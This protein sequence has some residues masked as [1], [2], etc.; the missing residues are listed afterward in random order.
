[1]TAYPFDTPPPGI[2]GELADFLYRAAN[3]PVPEIA[4]A[5]SIAYLAGV[6]GRA[7]NVS[8][9]GLNQYVLLVAGTGRGKEGARSG[10]QKFIAHATGNSW[11]DFDIP[12]QLPILAEYMGPADIASGQALIRN[13]GKQRS[14]ASFVGEFGYTMQRISHPRASSSDVM[15]LKVLL[16]VFMLSGE[17][18]VL[19]PTVYSDKANNTEAVDS[20]AFSLYGETS[21][22]TLYEG[23][24]VRMIANGFLPRFLPIFYEGPRVPQN[25]EAAT[26]LPTR[27]MVKRFAELVTFCTSMNARNEAVKVEIAPEA[28]P[29]IAPRGEVDTHADAIINDEAMSV[30]TTELWNRAHLKTLKLAALVAVGREHKHPVITLADAQW[31][32]AVVKHGIVALT[33]KFDAGEVGST[34]DDA[35]QKKVLAATVR[36]YLV[37][38]YQALGKYCRASRSM[39]ADHIIPLSYLQASLLQNKAFVNDR[40]GA[41]DALKRTI[42]SFID[43]GDLQELGRGDMQKYGKRGQAYAISNSAGFVE[44]A[45]AEVQGRSGGVFFDK[46]LSE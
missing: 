46:S 41:N 6:T 43:A 42:Q 39:H 16:D 10:V 37:S 25:P 30:V 9:T 1:M 29:F 38:E 28:V 4:L 13:I 34:T 14:C 32:Y 40:R 12:N 3:R 31:A 33:D 26:A 7:F 45:E 21:P 24:S 44:A 11:H 27:A 19:E 18:S 20:P 5:G 8:D 22:G 2:L 36:K 35:T 17:H 15:L 23:A